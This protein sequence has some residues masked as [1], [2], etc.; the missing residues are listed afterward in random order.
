[1]AQN[2][3]QL[4]KLLDFIDS[5]C[6]EEGNEWFAQKLQERFGAKLIDISQEL[7]FSSA[8][9]L[10]HINNRKKAKIFYKEI[11]DKILKEQI[12]AKYAQMLWYKTIYDYPNYFVCVHGQLENMLNYYIDHSDFFAKIEEYP[13]WYILEFGKNF[14]ID[15]N[16]DSHYNDKKGVI[17][18]KTKAT[19]SMWAKLVYWV[20]ETD[21]KEFEKKNH[22]NLSDIINIRNQTQHQ[23]SSSRDNDAGK[24]LYYKEGK[25]SFIE[26][27]LET[28]AATIIQLKS[29]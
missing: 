9:R 11:P 10:Q 24:W 18:R 25:F 12:I 23:D 6:Q 20:V 13:A 8:V 22:S 16:K 15:V 19:I 7:S 5:L 26:K 29:E 14:T 21:N 4:E 17:K 28:V 27:I 3:E 2:K 1:M